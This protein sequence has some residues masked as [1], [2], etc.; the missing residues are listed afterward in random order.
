MHLSRDSTQEIFFKLF[1][2]INFLQDETISVCEKQED[3][4]A[5]N[6]DLKEFNF[7]SALPSAYEFKRKIS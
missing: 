2:K 5:P 6:Y 4:L 7:C 1:G 3:Y